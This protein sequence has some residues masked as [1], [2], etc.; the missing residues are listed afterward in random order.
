M[1]LIKSKNE[2]EKLIEVVHVMKNLIL[3]IMLLSLV[4]CSTT[5]LVN[6]WKNPD[7]YQF[8]PTKILIVGM[9]NNLKARQQF[10]ESLKNEYQRRGIDA[11]TGIEVFGTS[12]TTEEKSV[13]EIKELEKQLIADGFDSVLFTKLS[14]IEDKLKHDNLYRDLNSS[15]SFGTFRDEFYTNQGIYYNPKSTIKYKVYHVETSLYCLCETKDRELIWKGLVDIT[16]PISK[17]STI[18]TYVKLLINTLE[19]QELITQGFVE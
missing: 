1:I 13:E 14:G 15:N 4:S 12:L 6:N 3:S 11:Y 19:E 10:E 18:D 9:T 17:K 2:S 16:D 5:R 8:T 7:I